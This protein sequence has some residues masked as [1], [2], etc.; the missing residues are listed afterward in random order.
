MLCIKTFFS[1]FIFLGTDD[2]IASLAIYFVLS[3]RE[4]KDKSFVSFC[5]MKQ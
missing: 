5:P 1:F 3:Y 4:A 2:T